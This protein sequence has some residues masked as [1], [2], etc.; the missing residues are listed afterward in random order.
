MTVQIATRI[1]EEQD[2]QFRETTKRLG[3]TPADAIRM[4]IAAFNERRGFPF[5]IRLS[6]NVEPFLTEEEASEFAD[7]MALRTLDETR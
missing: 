5:S 1:D 4:F 6:E 3:T 7:R 2:K